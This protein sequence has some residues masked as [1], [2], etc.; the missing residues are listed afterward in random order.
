MFSEFYAWAH[1]VCSYKSINFLQCS[2][3][4]ADPK[5][6]P[7]NITV[8]FCI[9][10][11]ANQCVLIPSPGRGNWSGYGPRHRGKGIVERCCQSA[12]CDLHHLE[13]YCA[14]SKKPEPPTTTPTTTTS[15]T[16]PPITST[17]PSTPTATPTVVRP[18][19]QRNTKW[20]FS[21]TDN[22]VW[23]KPQKY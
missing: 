18:V 9:H 7:N 19:W 3:K 6:N 23:K 17:T 22:S 20:A 11:G 2:I 21:H 15:T 12:G 13:M 14:K 1:S 16:S 5:T 8:C 10:G 4:S